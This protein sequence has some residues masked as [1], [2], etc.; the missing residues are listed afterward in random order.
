M[1]NIEAMDPETMLPIAF[2]QRACD[3]LKYSADELS[4]R[5]LHT[6]VIDRTEEQ[7]RSQIDVLNR[8]YRAL[9]PDRAEVPEVWK[10][11]VADVGIEF[12]L[13]DV[14]VP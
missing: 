11:L 1:A 4:H 12:A 8:D 10:E 14:P 3:Q 9:N 2:N 13:A 7:I 5:A 6:Y